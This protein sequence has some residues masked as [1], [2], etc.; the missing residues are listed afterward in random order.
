M[1]KIAGDNL[2]E[3]KKTVED[4]KTDQIIIKPNLWST[5]MNR[6][7]KDNNDNKYEMSSTIVTKKEP[8]VEVKATATGSTSENITDEGPSTSSGSLMELTKYNS[9]KNMDE[10][11]RYNTA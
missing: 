4:L 7:T 11:M 3:D 9:N 8:D 1:T 2:Q 5:T 6:D 10:I